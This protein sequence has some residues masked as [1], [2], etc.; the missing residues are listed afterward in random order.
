MSQLEL[1]VAVAKTGKYATSE[2]GDSAEIVERP[3]GGLSLV[4]ADG[5]RSGKAAKA[6]SSIVVRKAVALLAEGVRD[7]AVARAAHDYLRAMRGGKVSATLN[8]VSLDLETETIV[9]SRN[10]HCP[11]VL[12]RAEEALLLD[13]PS[14][15]V[16][17]RSW[18]RPVVVEL[19]IAPHTWVIAFTDGLL[20][21]GRRSGRPI[22]VLQLIQTLAEPDI[23][24]EELAD[25]ILARAIDHDL[26]RPQDD[27]SVVAV[28]VLPALPGAD[29]VRRMSVRLP[30]WLK[31]EV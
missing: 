6:I 21:A 13:E 26:G 10:S 11:T 15:P 27:I 5:Q 28:S 23:S 24:V 16:G 7:G 19:P 20:H 9:I 29:D 25:A 4:L 17:I 3:H 8:I 12:I 14:E 1:R 2:S 31:R 18:T 22:D 30:I